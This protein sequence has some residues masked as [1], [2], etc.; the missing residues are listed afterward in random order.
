MAFRLSVSSHGCYLDILWL[1][2]SLQRFY[3]LPEVVKSVAWYVMVKYALR[4]VFSLI[5]FLICYCVNPLPC[6]NN[7]FCNFICFLLFFS[8]CGP[9]FVELIR[10]CIELVNDDSW[11]L[12]HWL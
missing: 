10:W 2:K 9:I 8:A 7:M 3:V 4:L 5:F 12:L 1:Q 6:M 11:A